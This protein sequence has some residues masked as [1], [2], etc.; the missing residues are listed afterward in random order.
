MNKKISFLFI[1][2]IIFTIPICA[3]NTQD[4]NV[5]RIVKNVT[6]FL[7][8]ERFLNYRTYYAHGKLYII[9]G[10]LSERTDVWE[11]TIEPYLFR[12]ALEDKDNGDIEIVN[13]KDLDGMRI[14]YGTK[15]KMPIDEISDYKIGLRKDIHYIFKYIIPEKKAT[16]FYLSPEDIEGPRFNEGLKLIFKDNDEVKIIFKEDS[17][18]PYK[19]IYNK[20]EGL[21]TVRWYK[22]LA[23]WFRIDGIEVPKRVEYYREGVLSYLIEY[24][25]IK[26]NKNLDRK[27]FEI[28]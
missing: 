15:S 8:G 22:I 18:I 19:I 1:I 6:K 14:K 28:K 27:L 11:Y 5:E 16:I 23:R 25:K 10:Q 7:G 12:Q 2:I 3:Q 17:Y 20:K 4:K 21:S 13:L 9:K 24:D 26:F